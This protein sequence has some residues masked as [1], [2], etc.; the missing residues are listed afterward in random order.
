[1]FYFAADF[2]ERLLYC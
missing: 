2:Y 1:M